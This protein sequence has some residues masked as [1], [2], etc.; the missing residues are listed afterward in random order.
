MNMM[1]TSYQFLFENTFTEIV[2]KINKSGINIKNYLDKPISEVLKL[3][4]DQRISDLGLINPGKGDI[5]R[6]SF[7]LKEDSFLLWF[8]LDF[9]WKNNK[10][11]FENWRIIN[12]ITFFFDSIDND[13]VIIHLCL[14]DFI[15]LFK[16]G[17]YNTFNSIISTFTSIYYGVAY[18]G[19]YWKDLYISGKLLESYKA[20]YGKI[21]DPKLLLDNK[22]IKIQIKLL[23]LIDHEKLDSI[24][25]DELWI[26]TEAID[27]YYPSD[28]RY[29]IIDKMYYSVINTDQERELF[30]ESLNSFL[31]KRLEA[32]KKEKII[33]NARDEM[34]IGV[35][36]LIQDLSGKYGLEPQILADGL[37]DF[38]G[39]DAVDLFKDLGY[40]E[41]S[42][43]IK[44]KRDEFK[45]W[46]KNI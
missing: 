34:C 32:V 28:E 27:S 9:S 38:C 20:L 43:L 1:N 41:L 14:D 8:I 31:E 13:S 30:K 42:E 23:F 40:K 17:N 24:S 18:W 3:E 33:Y 45:Y 37:L 35:L 6:L 22:R 16:L 12:N 10:F 44:N 26:L 15:Y 25:P 39:S 46:S 2:D 5:I 36:E 7:Q 29:K 19:Q 4:P 21:K 11:Y